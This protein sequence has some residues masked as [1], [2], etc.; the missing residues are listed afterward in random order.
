MMSQFAAWFAVVV[1]IQREHGL[2]LVRFADR[3]VLVDLVDGFHSL[4][5]HL[6]VTMVVWLTG[7]TDAAALAGHDFDGMIAVWIACTHF[8]AEDLGIAE[9]VGNGDLQRDAVDVDGGD[10]NAFEAAELFE[11]ELRQ[12]FSGLDLVSGTYCCFDNAAG[13]AEDDCGTGGF[14]EWIVEFRFRQLCEVDVFE[15]DESCELAGGEN[16]VDIRIAIF[17]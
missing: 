9:A 14:A 15:L 10:A 16:D 2:V 8:I 6:F 3:H 11:I 12:W 13:G 7:A 5:E 1:A 4:Q 17:G